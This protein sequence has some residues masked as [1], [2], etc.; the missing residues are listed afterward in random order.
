MQMNKLIRLFLA[1]VLCLTLF[2]GTA[3]GASAPLSNT[4]YRLKNNMPLKIGYLGG[5][6]TLGTGASTTSACWREKTTKWFQD[7]YT[8]SEITAIN[9]TIG[10]FGSTPNAFRAKSQ[11]LDQNPDLVFV[12]A[13]VNDW[14]ATESDVKDAMEG[15]V[16]QIYT[17]NPK[18]DIVFIYTMHKEGAESSYQQG[19]VMKT[20]QWHQQIAEYY[21]IPS[22]N[23][24]LELYNHIKNGEMTWETALKDGTHPTDA[25]YQVY[26]DYITSMLETELGKDTSGLQNHNIQGKLF[27]GCYDQADIIDSWDMTYDGFEKSETSMGGRHPHMIVSDKKGATASVAFSGRAA[28]L[29]WMKSKDAGNLEWWVD[30]NAPAVISGCDSLAISSG[31]RGTYNMLATNLS[32]GNHTLHLR[33]TGDYGTGSN[34]VW[35]RIGGI[36][37]SAKSGTSA[38]APQESA[39]PQENVSVGV[40]SK[41]FS[42]LG[43]VFNPKNP[44]SVTRGEFALAA[45]AML[46]MEPLLWTEQ[47]YD[48]VPV[49]S[50]VFSTVNFLK[51]AGVLSGEGVFLPDR[52]ITFN[53][54][55]KML[56][57]CAGYTPLAEANGGY[58]NGYITTAVSAGI[59]DNV[60]LS[61]QADAKSLELMLYNTLNAGV[62]EMASYGGTL[63]YEIKTDFTVLNKF[64][65]V[66]KDKGVLNALSYT[67]LGGYN[68]MPKGSVL[69]GDRMLETNED[70]SGWFGRNISYYYKEAH[71]DYTLIFIDKDVNTTVVRA[72]S[73]DIEN[74]KDGVYTLK[75]PGD[76]TE[77]YKIYPYT[78]IIY[79]N[80]HVEIAEQY[81]LP[82][83][84]I[85]ELIDNNDDNNTDVAVILDYTT[86]MVGSAD[87]K[88]EI[89]YDIMQPGRKIELPSG[90]Y[91]ISNT[92][93]EVIN[94]NE[95]LKYD[96]ISLAIAPDGSYAEGILSRLYI[97]SEAS[98]II[99][100]NGERKFVI[101]GVPYHVSPDFAGAQNIKVGNKLMLYL[102]YNENIVYCTSNIPESAGYGYLIEA[103]AYSDIFGNTAQMKILT[104]DGK[105]KVM[106]T[107]ESVLINEAKYTGGEA[108]ITALNGYKGVINYKLSQEER[109]S[110]IYTALSAANGVNSGLYSED[111]AGSNLYYRAPTLNFGGKHVMNGHTVVF[112]VPTYTTDDVYYSAGDSSVFQSGEYYTVS[113]YRTDLQ[114]LTCDFIVWYDNGG[115]FTRYTLPLTLVEKKVSFVNDNNEA[116]EKLYGNTK[117]KEVEYISSEKGIFDNVTPGDIIR[118]KAGIKGTVIK[119]PQLIYDYEQAKLLVNIGSGV[120]STP[121]VIS[122]SVLKIDGDVFSVYIGG[123]ISS[124]EA[125]KTYLF[126]FNSK[127]PILSFDNTKKDDKIYVLSQNDIRD[128][129]MSKDNCTKLIGIFNYGDMD[130]LII[131][132]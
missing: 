106:Q 65:E 47:V 40:Y 109:V 125:D 129:A 75:K 45:A 130:E 9:A 79:N 43:I 22:I 101:D 13:A 28:G 122:G 8:D 52:P 105:V 73:E 107:K 117:G 121:W 108:I 115:D 66:Y 29:Y 131:Y 72:F 98:E 56:V 41:L 93:G 62:F 58:P 82:A 123:T 57:A 21:G 86:V 26:T 110:V 1:A 60:K 10:G 12:E 89:I 126:T 127:K 114:K 99:Q 80:Q 51:N 16:R 15:V 84:G 83:N 70:C 124:P 48:D 20:V 100:D 5:S 81:M 95:L 59:L 87:T 111:T 2:P 23:C 11:L 35:V 91:R 3:F 7:T 67:A 85:V 68:K 118:C 42:R 116:V 77:E 6:I 36:F 31:N 33:V 32:E 88:D 103:Q 38:A 97:S 69:I 25:G 44:N 113:A 49:S 94:L 132:K 46:K 104:A 14:N 30:N 24:G 96:V 18:T 63:N 19:T 90:Y 92:S 27:S 34:G 76:K 119:A 120:S 78:D 71:G 55:I 64:H 61:G 37:V 53:E 4:I 17:A 50:D 102:D 54:A 112:I 39:M 74:Y 128:Y